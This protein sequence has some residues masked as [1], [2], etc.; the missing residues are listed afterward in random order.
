MQVRS[1]GGEKRQMFVFGNQVDNFFS[2][3]GTFDSRVS[4][5]YIFNVLYAWQVLAYQSSGIKLGAFKSVNE[6]LTR[7]AVYISLLALYC[8]GGNKVRAVSFSWA[9][10]L[11]LCC[12]FSHLWRLMIFLTQN[13][14]F[15]TKFYTF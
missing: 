14:S 9:L 6:S 7:V 1:F 5:L 4:I 2:F 8:L 11:V 3:I 12:M 13:G 10:K 15:A